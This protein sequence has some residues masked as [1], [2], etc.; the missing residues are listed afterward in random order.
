MKAKEFLIKECIELGEYSK[1]YDGVTI[2]TEQ[3]AQ[4]VE[5]Y[6]KQAFDL[7]VVSNTEAKSEGSVCCETCDWARKDG[8]C[9]NQEPCENF[10]LWEQTDY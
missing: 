9:D 3:I 2:C 6:A 1:G 4:L 7:G 8:S 5:E 10:S